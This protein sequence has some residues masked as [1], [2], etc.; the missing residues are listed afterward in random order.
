MECI[1]ARSVERSETERFD[2]HAPFAQEIQIKM[3]CHPITLLVM[4][5][6]L[7]L[8]TSASWAL[9]PKGAELARAHEW[10]AAHFGDHASAAP[11]F[12]LA[13]DGKPSS[14]FVKTWKVKRTSRQIGG[15]P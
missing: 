11:P 5:S 13:Y 3:H 15:R 2:A 9:K 4:V 14:D 6:I 12:S 7:L 10:A 8:A 1:D